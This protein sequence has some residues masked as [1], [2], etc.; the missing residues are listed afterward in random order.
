MEIPD[1]GQSVDKSRAHI[2]TQNTAHNHGTEPK[3]PPFSH[4]LTGSVSDEQILMDES[5]KTL[6]K[7]NS[8]KDFIV[9]DIFSVK[10]PR[11]ASAGLS[12]G[13]KSI[14]KGF[15]L[16]AVSL[17]LC[18]IVGATKDGLG[19]F[20][21]GIGAGIL[22]AITLPVTSIGVAGYQITRG[23]M[24][25]PTAICEWSNG[26]KWNKKTREW[27]DDWYSLAEEANQVL[28]DSPELDYKKCKTIESSKCEERDVVD[29]EFYK[30]LEVP[31][32]ATQEEIRRQYYKIAK[33]CHPD[34]NTS[35]PNA[36][37]NFQ[38]LG[39]AY[40]VLGDEKRRAKYDKFG[41]SALESMPI[42]DSSLFFM[43]LFGSEILE[44]YIG[45]LR[46]AM[47][48]EIELEQ[49]VVST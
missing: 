45:K 6:S 32:T 36:A 9:G 44:P 29:D 23:V 42:I 41:K 19:G 7:N 47:F 43:M 27:G 4:L 20:F 12:S 1:F 48:V 34:K 25:T 40:Q 39:Q 38:K 5:G 33:K 15:G 22:S 11:D 21:K 31:T 8:N 2:E 37:D 16:G 10:M 26:R 3:I 17:V 30:I 13:I 14:G 49:S 28:K 35:D 46:M 18:P 24:N